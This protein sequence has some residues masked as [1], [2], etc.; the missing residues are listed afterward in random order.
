MSNR[1]PRPVAALAAIVFLSIPG[2]AQNEIQLLKG[3]L[4]SE[5]PVNFHDYRV[6]L[7]EINHH[8]EIYR[9]DPRLGG[10]FE[11]HRLPVGEYQLRVTT[12]H[13]DIVEQEFV[14]V[15]SMVGM[16]S[17]HL[18][19]MAK[20]P[21][22]SGTISMTQL[23]HPPDR[24]AMQSY[25]AAQRF[26]DSGSPEKAAEELEKAVRISPQFADAYTNLAVQHMRL[27][28]F[29]EAAGELTRA[30]EIAGPS[31]LRL[32]NLAYAQI[33]LG[34]R[35]ESLV[36]ARAALRMDSGYPQAHLILG[37]ILAGDR[38]TLA[39]SIPHLERA[40]ESIPAAQGT[41]ERARDAMRNSAAA[42]VTN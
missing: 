6:E 27:Q 8:S 24:K 23:R 18:S 33:N 42:H 28:R 4:R 21:S 3:E 10:E 40:A 26:A 29:Q 39:E 31:P 20:S 19:L 12:L 7:E 41:L 36:S 30:I 15:N 35:E 11:F 14:T 2:S 34:R 9:A 38:R 1:C 32:C 13:G 17:V 5:S 37:A 22:A 25:V 16:L